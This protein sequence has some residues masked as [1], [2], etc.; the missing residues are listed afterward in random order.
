MLTTGGDALSA[1]SVL[2]RPGE[3]TGR[4]CPLPV[5]H[6][7]TTASRAKATSATFDDFTIETVL[8]QAAP[9]RVRAFTQRHEARAAAV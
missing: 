3:V 5:E 1:G 9:V 4:P 8:Q 7:A 2:D 6:P